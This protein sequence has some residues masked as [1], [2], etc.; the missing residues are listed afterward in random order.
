MAPESR[1]NSNTLFAGECKNA[2]LPCGECISFM[3]MFSTHSHAS[4]IPSS[5]STAVGG[6]PSMEITARIDKKRRTRHQACID[7]NA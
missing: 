7:A 4:T 6:V 1:P 5:S 3:G 2:C